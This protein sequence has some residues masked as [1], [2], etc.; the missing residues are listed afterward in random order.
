MFLK[1]VK[2]LLLKPFQFL[3]SLFLSGLITLL[4]IALTI[5]IFAVA[6]HLVGNWIEPLQ[7]FRPEFLKVVPYSEFLVIIAVVIFFGII[8]RI[9]VLRS[10]INSAESII[11]KIPL[12][13]PVYTGIKQLVRAF[14]MQD[15]ISFKKVVLIEFPR[16]GMYSLGFLTSQLSPQL[17]PNKEEKFFSIFVPT[18]PNPTS[19]YFV[20][21]PEK[22]ITVVDLSHQ[23]AMALIISGGIIQ[24]DRYKDPI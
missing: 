23:E 2:G 7:Q 17:T 5:V 3:W 11:G 1:K 16:K 8:V 14:G 13:R 6:F 18:T 19:G 9:L 21:L 15:K 24:P 4:P 22:D 10:I 20:A 12:I